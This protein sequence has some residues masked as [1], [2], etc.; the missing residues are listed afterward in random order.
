MTTSESKLERGNVRKFTE[1][2]CD[3]PKGVA[4]PRFEE[5]E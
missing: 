2:S 3:A 4:Q 1:R 5:D